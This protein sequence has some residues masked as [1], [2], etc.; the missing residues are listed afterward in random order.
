M[1]LEENISRIKTLIGLDGGNNIKIISEVDEKCKKTTYT[2]FEEA[3]KF[4]KRWLSSDFTKEKFKKNWKSVNSS[5]TDEK[6]N[7]I[8]NQYISHL[9][10]IQLVF[11]DNKMTQVDGV[12]LGQD[13]SE[14]TAFVRKDIPNKI[15]C[16][17]SSLMKPN[18]QEEILSTL[19]HEITHSIEKI[20]PLNPSSKVVNVFSNPENILNFDPQEKRD[21]TI[22]VNNKLPPEKKDYDLSELNRVM[23]DLNIDSG[24]AISVIRYWRNLLSITS[25]DEYICDS[26]E[27]MSNIMAMRKK[28]L[29]NPGQKMSKQNIIPYILRDKENTD[30]DFFILCWVLKKFRPLDEVINKTNELAINYNQKI[31]SD[32]DFA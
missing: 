9:D 28:L 30:F 19:I 11:F 16:N 20:H 5:W 6:I 26:A 25:D 14:T 2:E 15:F 4:M 27:K 22:V 13:K 12:Q 31:D 29:I 10:K 7:S 23:K 21:K 17:C 32:T 18:L 3:K 8:F 24:L 1:N